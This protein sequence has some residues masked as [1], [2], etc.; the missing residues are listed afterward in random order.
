VRTLIQALVAA[1]GP[2]AAGRGAE[3]STVQL[4]GQ[5]WHALPSRVQR[6]MHEIF[7]HPEQFNYEDI[8]AR[9]LQSTR[10]AGMFVVGDLGTALRDTLHDPGVHDALDLASPEVFCQLCKLSPSAAD[11]VRL[12]SSSEYAEARW[13]SDL[14]ERRGVLNPGAKPRGA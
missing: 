5:L 10:R 7:A 12:A 3:S 6:R 1:F 14:P 11:L 13:R 4:A 2:P 8:W 9:A